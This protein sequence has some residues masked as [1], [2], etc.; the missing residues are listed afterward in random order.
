MS[1]V[2]SAG[3]IFNGRGH[4]GS[5]LGNVPKGYDF[6]ALPVLSKNKIDDD[7]FIL[8]QRKRK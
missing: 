8:L 3:L 4:L 6:E 1:P 7:F 2:I 5:L